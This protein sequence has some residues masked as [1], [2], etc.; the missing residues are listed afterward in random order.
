MDKT[1]KIGLWIIGVLL[2]LSIGLSVHTCNQAS[3]ID[4]QTGLLN[5]LNDKVKIWKD[6]EGKSHTSNSVITTQNPKDFINLEGLSEENKKLQAQVKKYEKQIKNGGSVTN[7]TSETNVASTTPTKV[8]TV[9]IDNTRQAVYSTTFNK[10]GWV[11]GSVIARPDSTTINVGTKDEYTV[12]IGEDRTGFLGLGK[13][14]PFSEITNHNPY[15]TTPTLKT[16]QVDVKG[17]KNKWVLPT[18]VGT[19]IGVVGTTLILKK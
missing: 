11:F 7:F 16:Y 9:V 10:E 15:S 12:V 2:L 18:V 19:V 6:K 14:I 5:S 4:E 1:S 17:K 13:P 3:K 8:D